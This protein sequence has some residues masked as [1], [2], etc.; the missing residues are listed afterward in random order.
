MTTGRINQI[1]TSREEA[2]KRL[3]GGTGPSTLSPPEELEV[4]NRKG[5]APA[6]TSTRPDEDR[7]CGAP[8]GRP[9]HSFAPSEFLR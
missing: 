5:T 4:V 3:E 2:L 7:P 1:S 6:L 9:R 8:L